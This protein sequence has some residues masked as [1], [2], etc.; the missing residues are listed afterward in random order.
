MLKFVCRNQ[1]RRSCGLKIK[2]GNKRTDRRTNERTRPNLLPY[3][4][5]RSV[6]VDS[7]DTRS[8]VKGGSLTWLCMLLSGG[9]PYSTDNIDEHFVDKL[10]RGYRLDKPTYATDIMYASF[11]LEVAPFPVL[12]LLRPGSAAR[13]CDDRVSVR[14]F[15]FVRVYSFDLCQ[16]HCTCYL[17]P[18]LGPSLAALRYVMCFRYPVLRMTSYLHIM[19]GMHGCWCNA[20]TASQPDVQPK[21]L[22]GLSR[23][24]IKQQAVSPYFGAY[25]LMYTVGLFVTWVLVRLSSAVP[26]RT[27]R[28]G[29]GVKTKNHNSNSN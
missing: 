23:P 15:V 18:W 24:W 17:W 11:H 1:G 16:I 26:E 25:R 12:L 6:N 2:R 22:L 4:W 29:T 3:P 19:G 14:A 27:I 9:N 21:R 28:T 20:G 5:K 13:Y 7:L 10:K 8:T